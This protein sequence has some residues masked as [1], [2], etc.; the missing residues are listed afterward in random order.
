MSHLCRVCEAKGWF[1]ERGDKRSMKNCPS[2]WQGREDYQAVSML[3]LV[4]EEMDR[5]FNDDRQIIIWS[6]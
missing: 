5:L 6:Q 3:Y 4:E 2:T 1:G